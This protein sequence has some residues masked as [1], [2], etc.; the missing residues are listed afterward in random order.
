M[1]SPEYSSYELKSIISALFAGLLGVL[2]AVEE[3]QEAGV[4]VGFVGGVV[5]DAAGMGGGDVACGYATLCQ[6]TGDV[7][8]TGTT[9]GGVNGI[10]ACGTVGGSDDLDV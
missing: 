6:F 2:R 9:E 7:V 5:V 8:S 3:H 10:G 4:A 1:G